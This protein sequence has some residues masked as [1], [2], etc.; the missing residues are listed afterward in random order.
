MTSSKAATVFARFILFIKIADQE[1][2]DVMFQW[3]HHVS[4]SVFE[5]RLIGTQSTIEASTGVQSQRVNGIEEILVDVTRAELKS[6]ANIRPFQ[7]TKLIISS[8]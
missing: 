4:F 7:H 1:V 5:T 3:Q 8:I 6:W 2:V